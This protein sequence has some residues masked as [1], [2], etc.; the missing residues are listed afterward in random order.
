[1]FSYTPDFVLYMHQ[2]TKTSQNKNK[3]IFFKFSLFA[4]VYPRISNHNAEPC[5]LTTITFN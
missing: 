3:N 5:E 2:Y 1:M 4:H